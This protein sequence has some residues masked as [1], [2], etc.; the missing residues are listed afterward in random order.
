[1]MAIDYSIFPIPKSRPRALDKEDRKKWI[2]STDKVEDKKVKARSKGQC[3]V[4]VVGHGRCQK[5]AEGDPHHMLGGWGR[6]AR[7]R[8]ALAK[9]KQHCCRTHH[10]AITNHTL[11]LLANGDLPQWDDAYERVR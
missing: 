9:H 3:E 10:R 5:R 7:G 6:R 4:F 8:S 1:V 11:R 2:A